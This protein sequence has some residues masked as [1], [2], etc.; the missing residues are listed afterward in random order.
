[1]PQTAILLHAV[2]GGLSSLAALWV[3]IEVLNL[4]E[5]NVGRIGYAAIITTALVWGAYLI[6]G[7]FYVTHYGADKA[8]IKAGRWPWAH[9]FFM[10]VKEHLFFMILLL[11]TYLPIVVKRNNLLSNRYAR[12][13]T[14]AVSGMI[15][16]LAQ[17]MEGAGAII[18]MGVK[19]GLLK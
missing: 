9:G 2:L 19:Q 13:L 8:I 12:N 18:A 14:L 6:G 4:N 3:F 10:E 5:S 17:A 11:A 1:M 7:W 16:L 15:V